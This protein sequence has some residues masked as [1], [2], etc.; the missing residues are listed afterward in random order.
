LIAGAASPVER[1]VEVNACKGFN[2]TDTTVRLPLDWR[3][4]TTAVPERGLKGTRTATEE[5]RAALAKAL[6]LVSC[7]ALEASYQI[8]PAAG[9]GYRL[10]GGIDAAVTQACIITLEPVAGR[11]A[12]SFG[13][14]FRRD[15]ESEAPA[16]DIDIL[17]SADVEPL[18]DDRIDVGR[19][20][21][22]ALSA[23][24][25]PYPRKEG[26]EFEWSDAKQAEGKANPFAVLKKL[27][28]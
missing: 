16:G 15:A 24:L 23:G 7:D 5:E 22:E 1:R 2:M 8:S 9:G 14:E 3:I 28:D 11:V 25:D 6:D 20:V 27:K 21:Y 19:I 10:E 17:S 12:E 4:E 26:A 13:V 18:I